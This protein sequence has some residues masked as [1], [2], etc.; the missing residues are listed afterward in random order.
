MKLRPFLVDDGIEPVL[1]WAKTALAASMVAFS[2]HPSMR[3]YSETYGITL[4]EWVKPPAKAGLELRQRVLKAAGGQIR[5][6]K[7]GGVK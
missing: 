6:Y 4:P 3:G 2:M 7:G 5:S 1:V